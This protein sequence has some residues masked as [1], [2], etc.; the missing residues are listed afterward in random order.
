MKK[1]VDRKRPLFEESGDVDS[2][3]RVKPSVETCESVK[4]EEVD[5]YKQARLSFGKNTKRVVFL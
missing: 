3:E 1:K 5:N 2:L 4:E